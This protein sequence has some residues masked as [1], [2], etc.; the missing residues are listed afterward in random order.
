[1]AEKLPPCPSRGFEQSGYFG[2]DTSRSGKGQADEPE[3]KAAE[4][5]V[6]G[7][8]QEMGAD[9]RCERQKTTIGAE[10]RKS[11]TEYDKSD[12]SLL[13]DA[14]SL[15]SF[16]AK[17][18]EERSV[19]GEGDVSLYAVEDERQG[20]DFDD[21]D[22]G[23]HSSDSSLDLHTPLVRQNPHSTFQHH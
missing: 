23:G 4:Y 18:G 6:R 22:D 11:W 3:F 1:M 19:V 12:L 13:D 15:R 7:E 2:Y 9:C 8:L 16:K 14:V 17:D 21:G 10:S 20:F 5:G